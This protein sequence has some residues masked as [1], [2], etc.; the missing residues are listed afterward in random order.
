[1]Y[2]KLNQRWGESKMNAITL[3]AAHT[4]H[5]V[6]LVNRINKENKQRDIDFVLF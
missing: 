1:M 3:E 2:N 4:H 6:C 5:T